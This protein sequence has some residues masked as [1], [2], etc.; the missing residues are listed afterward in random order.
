MQKDKIKANFLNRDRAIKVISKDGLFRAVLIKNSNTAKVAQQKHQL[1][2]A[3]AYF[4]SR[5][6]TGSSMLAALLKGEERVVLSIEGAGMI[7]YISAEALQIGEVRG[8]LRFKSLENVGQSIVK[9]ED[10]LGAGFLRVTKVMYNQAQPVQGI[11]PL[12]F[13]DIVND[14][15]YYFTQSEQVPTFLQMDSDFNDDGTIKHSGGLMI[16]SLPN[17]SQAEIEKLHEFLNELPPVCDLFNQDISPE[18][19]LKKLLPF[20]YNVLSSTPL[21]F[22]CRCSKDVFK[23]KLITLGKAELED[24]HRMNHNELV[25]QFCNAHYYL[26]NEDFK[27]LIAEKTAKL[28]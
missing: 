25:C 9:L 1:Q 17:A 28:N 5:V 16:Q 4:L 6:L 2:E 26:T 12:Q 7:S 15:A 8:F 22:F 14:L 21:D 20:E 23:G 10:M 3:G 18:E 11:I 19:S 24:M 27:E 13:G